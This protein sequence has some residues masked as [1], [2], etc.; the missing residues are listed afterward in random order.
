MDKSFLFLLALV[1]SATMFASEGA[2]SGKFTINAQGDQV[3][4]SQGN[5]QYQASTQTWRFATNQYDYVGDATDGNVYVG[6]TK[7]DNSLISDTYD[8]WIDLFGWGTGDKPILTTSTYYSNFTAYVD[9]GVNAISN[10]GNEANLWRTLTKDEW[11]YIYRGRSGAEGLRGHASIDGV[12]GFMFFPDGFT[13]PDGLG[14]DVATGN[15]E[16][17][18]VNAFT[19]SQWQ[20]LE[21][22]GVVFLPAAGF[23]G[24]AV[25]SVTTLGR[26]WSSTAFGDAY[27][28]YFVSGNSGIE[29]DSR[30]GGT[31]SVL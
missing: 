22:L 18:T 16:W 20:S 6:E 14:F 5:L 11:T 21:Q 24:W 13:I 2:L 1:A 29:Q 7:S 15:L 3:V 31:P 28:M 30:P 9:W 26:Y 23:R 8:G 17:G 12:N 25:G 27:D 10:G 4:F 19:E